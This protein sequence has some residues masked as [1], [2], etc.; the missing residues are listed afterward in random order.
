MPTSR[1]EN[2]DFGSSRVVASYRFILCVRII[3]VLL[4]P[5]AQL[6]DLDGDFL[7]IGFLQFDMCFVCVA[8]GRLDTELARQ[9]GKK[10]RRWSLAHYHIGKEN[11]K[12]TNRQQ[13]RRVAGARKMIKGMMTCLVS[14]RPC[15]NP[16]E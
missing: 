1:R 7:T 3:D 11:G 5:F 16:I 6:S 2:L 13:N 12:R 10:S 14:T 9:V 15:G 8:D 4:V